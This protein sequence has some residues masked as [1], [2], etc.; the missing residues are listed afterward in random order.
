MNADA[1]E[2]R[3]VSMREDVLTI[4]CTFLIPKCT[5]GRNRFLIPKRTFGRNRFGHGLKLR[6]YEKLRVGVNLVFTQN[7]YCVNQ[8]GRGF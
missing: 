1:R 6:P 2:M 3:C 8:H 7:L 5:F 4:K